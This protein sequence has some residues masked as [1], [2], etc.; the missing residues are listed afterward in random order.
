MRNN[1]FHQGANGFCFRHP[2]VKKGSAM[3]NVAVNFDVIGNQI[4]SRELQ[5]V[6]AISPQ[7]LIARGQERAKSLGL[8]Y[9]GTVYPPEAWVLFKSGAALLIDIRTIEERKFVGH[10]LESLHVA[11]KFGTAMT[12]NPRFQRELEKIAP[13]DAVVLLLCRSGKRS[14]EAAEAIAKSGYINAF[15]VLEGFEGELDAL[16]HRGEHDG[17]RHWGLPWVQD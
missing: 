11:W 9:A 7:D 2:S 13:K 15:N 10:V 17:W 1:A 12:A 8:L 14:A 16:Q 6:L 5:S 3:S 4:L